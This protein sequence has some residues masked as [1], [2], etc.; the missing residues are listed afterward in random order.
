MVI[1]DHAGR[2]TVALSKIV[3]QPMGPLEIEAKP[4]VEGVT[5]AWDV[6]I[7]NVIFEGDSKIVFDA[8]MWL[9]QISQL[10]YLKGLKVFGQKKVSHVK[11]QGNR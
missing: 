6:G 2:V 4:M 7:R 5:F 11:R 9:Y 8:L 1:R 10:E 3:H